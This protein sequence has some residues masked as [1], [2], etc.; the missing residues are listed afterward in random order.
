MHRIRYVGHNK[1][2]CSGINA[3]GDC[4]SGCCRFSLSYEL[5][6]RGVEVIVFEK[7][8]W[9][10]GRVKTRF[11][12]Y[13]PLDTGAQFLCN[14]YAE[15]SRLCSELGINT[16][17]RVLKPQTHH[18][19]YKGE[20]HGA[21]YSSP[22]DLFRLDHLSTPSRLRLIPFLWRLNCL[23]RG[24]S[25]FPW[26]ADSSLDTIN[27]YDFT[28]KWAGQEVADCFVDAFTAG[29]HFHGAKEL[30]LAFLA[31]LASVWK[32]E[33][34]HECTHEGIDQIAQELAKCVP[35]RTQS[36][37]KEIQGTQLLSDEGVHS[38]DAIV[39]AVSASQALRVLK[40]ADTR[41][42]DF[43]RSVEYA[44]TI[45]CA[46]ACPA[47]PIQQIAMGVVSEGEGSGVIAGFINQAAKYPKIPSGRSLMSVFLR[48]EAAR[49]RMT[50]TDEELFAWVK[51]QFLQVCPPLRGQEMIPCEIQRWPEA[52]PKYSLG[53]LVKTRWFMEELQGMNHLFFAG[54]YLNAP[55][56]EG[57]LQRGRQVA[58][59]LYDMN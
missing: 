50:Q 28:K 41:V 24:S 49:Q 16:P 19:F 2:Q 33:I 15:T 59:R 25:L 14:A 58:Q 46:Y 30:S 23:S 12:P 45:H 10:G 43:L 38:F 4:R 40:G 52:I 57:S 22:S 42:T 20:L 27:A 6:K 51:E 29:Y 17:W 1:S 11:T 56:I 53:S 47:E 3:R 35:V 13:Q 54:D 55:W 8:A 9:V 34:I 48:D 26:D 39:V 32:H 36:P 7:E 44:A 5:H 21:L 18:V 31:A 37:I